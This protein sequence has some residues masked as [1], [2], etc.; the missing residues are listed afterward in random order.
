MKQKFRRIYQS[1]NEV[2]TLAKTRNNFCI[3]MQSTQFDKSEM[4]RYPSSP[5]PLCCATLG[6]QIMAITHEEASIL[7]LPSLPAA[8]LVG[9]APP[10]LAPAAR[11]PASLGA[12]QC[13]ADPARSPLP[14]SSFPSFLSPDK[15][16]CA[17]PSSMLKI[18]RPPRTPR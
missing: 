3:L 13:G 14:S 4:K 1:Y 5:S 8:P 6:R 7:V 16:R 9:R 12:L 2:K 17:T 18:P 15:S 11:Q 10:P